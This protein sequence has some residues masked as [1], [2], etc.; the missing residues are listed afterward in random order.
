MSPLEKA[1]H[2]ESGKLHG[3]YG[4]AQYS[5]SGILESKWLRLGS[6]QGAS[7][8]PQLG[9]LE[10][11]LHVHVLTAV[12]SDDDIEVWVTSGLE[13]LFHVSDELLHPARLVLH[14]HGGQ[15]GKRSSD[16]KKGTPTTSSCM[17]QDPIGPLQLWRKPVGTQQRGRRQRGSSP[18]KGASVPRC[19]Q[20]LQAGPHGKA[21]AWGS[22]SAFSQ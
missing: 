1:R 9:P 15:Q 13:Q 20:S 8:P 5:A 12:V 16:A 22:S 14:Y 7:S 3:T 21:W 2:W 10:G 4:S 19:P 18:V 11:H 6:G 17:S